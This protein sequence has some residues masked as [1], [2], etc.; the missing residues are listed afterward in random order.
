MES[1]SLI[2]AG[3]LL[4]IA[5]AN[6]ITALAQQSLNGMITGINR[7]DGS[8]SI[9]QIASGTVGSEGGAVEQFRAKVDLLESVHAG[10]RVTYSVT[11]S[12]GTKTITKLERQK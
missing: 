12:N 3:S 5:T 4:S 10:D 6:P 8:I 7:M 11:D 2:V 1:R 9:Q